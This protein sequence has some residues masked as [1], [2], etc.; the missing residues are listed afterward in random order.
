MAA[1]AAMPID[2]HDAA[3]AVLHDGR[4]DI[5]HQRHHG[6][7]LQRDR[8]GEAHV[9]GGKAIPAGGGMTATRPSILSRR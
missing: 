5:L 4:D 8:S 6:R 2:D 1:I 3:E 9:M 7:C